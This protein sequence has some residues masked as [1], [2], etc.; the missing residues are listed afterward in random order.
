M[1][2]CMVTYE[3]DLTQFLVDRAN[4]DPISQAIEANL[5]DKYLGIYDEQDIRDM[6]DRVLYE[7]DDIKN[8]EMLDCIMKRNDYLGK[9]K[10]VLVFAG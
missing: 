5:D 2:L 7:I 1:N 3:G 6:K 10:E 8:M 4:G 9:Y